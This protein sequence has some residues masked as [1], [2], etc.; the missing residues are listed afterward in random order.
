MTPTHTPAS[1]NICSQVFL[2]NRFTSNG[3][4]RISTHAQVT[5]DQNSVLVDIHLSDHSSLSDSS[6]HTR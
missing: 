5:K 1:V 4:T 6:Y 3:K 2:E